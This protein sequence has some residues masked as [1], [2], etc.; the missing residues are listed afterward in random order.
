MGFEVDEE[1]VADFGGYLGAEA[2][3]TLPKI[4][5]LARDEGMSDHGFLGL[6]EPLGKAVNG[7]ASE[8]VGEGF[9]LMQTKMC[10]LADGVIA[11]AKSY[12]YTEETNKSTLERFGLDDN[13]GKEVTFGR[14]E[15]RYDPNASD[16]DFDKPRRGS[17]SQFRTTELSDVSIDRPDTK[18]T[19]DIDV[20]P[21]LSVLDWIWSEF[22]VD[23][24][25]GFTDSIIS[26][27]AGNYNSINANGEA[28]K[29]VGEQFGELVGNM[30]TN[31]TTLAANSWQG[32]AAEAFKQFIDVFWTRGAA[33]AGQKVGEFIALGFEKIAD[34]SKQ[35]AQLA[36][37]AINKIIKLAAK[38]GSKF[39]PIV[40]WAWTAIEYGAWLLGIDVDAL[41]ENIMQI[42]DLAQKVFNLYENIE[43]IVTTM[44]DYFNNA[45]ELTDAVKKIPEI[46]SL[47][48]AVSTYETIKDKGTEMEKQ[49]KEIDKAAT[50]ADKT[51]EEIDQTVE[52]ATG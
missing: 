32:D 3:Q 19:D 31:A 46:G 14:Y 4:E 15:Y 23:G 33:W 40:G 26:P 35:L 27:L 45:Q 48:D 20:G 11:A 17:Y 7:P 2:S 25:K 43:K 52:E 18:Y 8:L 24:G 16:Q 10:D 42:I 49:L 6:L 21:V 51:L 50:E 30:G 5:R 29:K 13:P 9:S 1:Q 38:I 37:D 41:H 28:W 36:V 34:A 22:N 44:E 47:E 39:I 12:G